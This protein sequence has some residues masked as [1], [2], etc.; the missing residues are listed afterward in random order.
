WSP[1]RRRSVSRC[2]RPMT[3]FAHAGPSRTST[4]VTPAYAAPDEG[5]VFLTGASGFVGGHVLDALL[6]RGYRVRALV[7]DSTELPPGAAAV[8]GDLRSPSALVP[9]L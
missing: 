6:A 2:A 3:A 5:D 7:R 4:E 9:A 1:P 8:S